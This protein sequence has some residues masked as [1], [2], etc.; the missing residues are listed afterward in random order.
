MFDGTVDTLLS[1]QVAELVCF[2]I[3]LIRAARCRWGV[4]PR[5]TLALAN[6]QM[7]FLLSFL[8]WHYKIIKYNIIIYYKQKQAH[9]KV[10]DKRRWQETK[11]HKKENFQVRKNRQTRQEGNSERGQPRHNQ[12][13]AAE[14][15]KRNNFNTWSLWQQRL[16]VNKHQMDNMAKNPG[17]SCCMNG[18]SYLSSRSFWLTYV[19]G[20]LDLLVCHAMPCRTLCIMHHQM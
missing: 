11:R 13:Q 7:S 14:C 9:F 20:Y 2:I 12:P 6:S 4:A 15:W 1:A 3:I 19:K 8:Y 5:L 18:F 10:K 16:K 17:H